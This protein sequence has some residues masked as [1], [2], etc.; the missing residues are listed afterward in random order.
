M[1]DDEFRARLRKAVM[2]EAGADDEAAWT[3]FAAR[4]SNIPVEYDDNDL[5]GYAELAHR[6]EMVDGGTSAGAR[7]LFYLATPPA[8]FAP[9]MMHLSDAKLAGQAYQPAKG[10]WARFVIEKPF[11]RDLASARALNADIARS[12]EE[13]DI[14]RIDHFLVKAIVQNLFVLRFANAFLNPCGIATTSIT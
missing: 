3:D 4:L 7:R 12:F 13:H 8:L 9:I 6:F 10:D 1:T 11:G 2:R 14:Y 5:L